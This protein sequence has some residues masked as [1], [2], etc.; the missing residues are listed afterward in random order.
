MFRSSRHEQQLRDDA[1]A[2]AAEIL[3]P[4]HHGV[5]RHSRPRAHENEGGC[6]CCCGCINKD[7]DDRAAHTI[8]SSGC[9]RNGRKICAAL[10]SLTAYL[11]LTT[12]AHQPLPTSLFSF[13]STPLDNRRRT[14]LSSVTDKDSVE[15]YNGNTIDS[16]N[17]SECAISFGTYRGGNEYSDVRAGTVGRPKCLV[18]S[19]FL[20]VQQHR[21]RVKSEDEDGE[22]AEEIV[23]D[24]LWIDYHDRVNV[25]VEAP[26]N[27][28]NR[29]DFDEDGE[30][31]RR[32]YVFEQTKYALEGRQSLAIV[33]GIVEPGEVPESAA[34]REVAEELDATTC[35]R[36]Q[37]LGRYRTDVNR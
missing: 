9:F 12:L 25:L 8:K 3:L 37:F 2:A 27:R 20:K 22:V 16:D 13:M 35:L 28:V 32:F 15:Q 11:A 5:H 10:G 18:E 14:S 34:R 21:V 4:T 7:D 24:W 17:D 31:G 30:E 19:K 33:G 29:T 1:A 26:R 36:Y 23:E 6:I